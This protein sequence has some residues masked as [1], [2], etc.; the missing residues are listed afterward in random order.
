MVNSRWHLRAGP[1]LYRFETQT[2]QKCPSPKKKGRVEDPNQSFL[3]STFLRTFPFMLVFYHTPINQTWKIHRPTCSTYPTDPPFSLSFLSAL[4][5]PPGQIRFRFEE[6]YLSFLSKKRN[7]CAFLREFP[8]PQPHK[9]LWF[10]HFTTGPWGDLANRAAFHR[11]NF[12]NKKNSFEILEI[13]TPNGDFCVFSAVEFALRV[14]WCSMLLVYYSR[15]ISWKKHSYAFFSYRSPAIICSWQSTACI[16]WIVN[17]NQVCTLQKSH[18]PSFERS[19]NCNWHGSKFLSIP[20]SSGLYDLPYKPEAICQIGKD[21]D[22]GRILHGAPLASPVESLEKAFRIMDKRFTERK[23][24]QS[25]TPCWASWFRTR[26]P[27][28]YPLLELTWNRNKN[29]RNVC[30]GCVKIEEVILCL[31]IIPMFKLVSFWCTF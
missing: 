16:S 22:L 21:P 9:P 30:M 23:D 10:S 27:A 7:C 17:K 11:C 18:L 20:F 8:K 26:V 4:N 12:D 14:N 3:R 31:Y 2:S 25:S 1:H 29:S 6:W 24:V 19:V 5:D 13:T 15:H 28:S